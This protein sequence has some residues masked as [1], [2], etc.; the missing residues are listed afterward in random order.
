[1][2][3]ERLLR[4]TVS[5]LGTENTCNVTARALRNGPTRRAIFKYTDHYIDQ[6]LRNRYRHNGHDLPRV[7]QDELDMGRALLRTVER[8]L[9]RDN[10][11]ETV[12]KGLLR[13]LLMGTVLRENNTA[14]VERF[15]KEHGGYGPPSFLLISPGKL[16]N[17][18]CKGCYAC[19]GV[20]SEKLEWDV[21]DRIIT[22]AKTEWGSGFIVIS[23]GEPFAYRSQN[24]GILDAAARHP[25]TLFLVYTNGTLIDKETAE[26]IADLGNITPAI[27][28][29]GWEEHTDGRRGKGVYQRILTAMDN[30]REAGAVFGMSLTATRDNCEVLFSDEYLDYFFEEKGVLYGWIFQYMPIGRGITLD[31]MPTPEQRAWMWER[32]WQVVREKRYFL[33][34]FWNSGTA[35]KGCISAGRQGGYLYIDWDGQV[36]PCA[37]VPYSPVN[38]VEAYEDGKTLNDILEEPFFKEI[39][40]WQRRY[41]YKSE[42][43]C[44]GGNW[45]MPCIIRD[46][47]EEF[48][49]ILDATEP[50]PIDE[51]ALQALSDPDYRQGLIKYDQELAKIM[52]PVWQREYVDD[53]GTNAG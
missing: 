11:P 40:E 29:E 49:H 44:E 23:G 46:H 20:N 45:T 24:L 32:T 35:S 27:S 17:L 10:V 38:I 25:D 30:L 34:D 31:L 43:P 3:P 4:W 48:R 12:L 14:S 16:C 39:R 52:D 33:A 15:L 22:E 7:M 9:E 18:Q 37:F 6:T 2:N 5:R 41:G 28:M 42:R 19:S 53:D 47:H 8:A 1:M 21:F 26:R 51:G 50:D 13:S 36:M